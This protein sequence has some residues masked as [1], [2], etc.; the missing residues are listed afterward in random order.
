MRI[1]KTWHLLLKIRGGLVVMG[2]R[3]MLKVAKGGGGEGDI[4]AR[5]A[6]KLNDRFGKIC[7]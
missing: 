4:E 7:T 2:V 6:V 5:R 1:K 3:V